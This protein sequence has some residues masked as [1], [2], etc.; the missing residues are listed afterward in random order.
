MLTGHLRFH[1]LNKFGGYDILGVNRVP[2][3]QHRGPYRRESS[4][5]PQPKTRTTEGLILRFNF[6]TGKFASVPVNMKYSEVMRGSEAAVVVQCPPKTPRFILVSGIPASGKST[7]GFQL[8]HAVDLPVMDKDIILEQLFE[9]HPS[10]HPQERNDLSRIPDEIFRS[11]VRSSGGAIVISFW[12]RSE[13]S[14][15]SGTP[16]LICVQKIAQG[17]KAR[18]G[19]KG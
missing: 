3:L 13:S 7:L 12:Q 9:S 17:V 14:Q 15:T 8:G 19:R 4:A 11:Q 16:T 18:G 6:L 2:N 1:F 10:N 5:E